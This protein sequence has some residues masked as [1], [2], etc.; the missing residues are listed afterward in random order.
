MIMFPAQQGNIFL[1]PILSPVGGV[2]VD[3]VVYVRAPHTSAFV[4]AE[5]HAPAGEYLQ[6]VPRS[7]FL[8]LLFLFLLSVTVA[9]L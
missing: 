7:A 1:C 2:V 3:V 8:L 9:G 6:N 4:S 5:T